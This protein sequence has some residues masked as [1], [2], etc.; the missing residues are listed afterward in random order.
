MYSFFKCKAWAIWAYLGGV[1]I[2]SLI[3]AQTYCAVLLNEWYGV[4]YT[5]LQNVELHT[6]NEFWLSLATFIYIAMPYVFLIAITNFVSRVYMLRWRQSIAE[7][8]SSKWIH[9]NTMIEGASQRIQEDT[10]RFAQI[11]GS[12]GIEAIKGIAV[13]TA[14]I[15]ILWA[16]SISLVVPIFGKTTG[17]LVWFALIISVGGIIISWFVGIKL[18]KLEYN[19]RKTEAA[20]RKEL[21]LGEDKRDSITNESLFSLFTGLRLNHQ[22]LYLHQSYFDLW[23][24]LYGQSVVILPFLIGGEGLF[25]GILTLGMLIQISNCFS[26]VNDSFSIILN[27]WT[28]ITELRS[29]H[30]RL[31]EF[32]KLMDAK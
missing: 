1:G 15:P 25:S 24:S 5:I 10:A 16:L 21:V 11:L 4:F 19:N 28:A 12:L 26:K 14:F 6:I 22:R 29:I 20:Y 30:L 13:L 9:T 2:I 31:T 3:I 18:P 32:Y 7:D 23:A 17:S 8:M 27:R